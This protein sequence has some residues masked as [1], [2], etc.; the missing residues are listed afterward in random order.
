MSLSTRRYFLPAALVLFVM[1][2]SADRLAAPTQVEAAFD[3]STPAFDALT[4]FDITD[5]PV[6]VPRPPRLLANTNSHSLPAATAGRNGY[7]LDVN[8]DGITPVDPEIDNYPSGFR[9]YATDPTDP[10][11]PVK[12]INAPSPSAGTYLIPPLDTTSVAT[13]NTGFGST[14]D[15]IYC[16]VVRAPAGYQQLH[17]EWHYDDGVSSDNV[18]ALPVIPIINVSLKKIGDGL[19]GGPAEVCTVGW[20][21][22]FI[23]GNVSN[24]FDPSPD[25]V[26]DLRAPDGPDPSDFVIVGGTNNG[27]PVV[28]YV[29][30]NGPEWCAGIGS[31]VSETGLGLS[32]NID[33]IYN[34]VDIGLRSRNVDDQ[35]VTINL[36]ADQSIDIVKSVELRHITMDGQISQSQV[37]DAKVI[38]APHYVCLIGSN[39]GVN[40][41]LAASGVHIQ[42]FGPPQFANV[43]GLAVFTK[44]ASDNPRLGAVEDDTLCF[45]YTSTAPGEQIIY[46]DYTDG[47]SGLPAQS[48]FDTNN[49]GNGVSDFPAGSLTTAWNVIDRTVLSTGSISSGVVTFKTLNVPLSFNLSDGTFLGGIG[50]TE[51][52]LGEHTAGGKQKTDQLLDGVL[53]VAKVVGNCGYFEVPDK[54]KVTTITGISVGGRL[55]LNNFNDDPF[56]GFHGDTDADPD[57][58]HITTLNAGGCGGNAK[59][60][61]KVNVYYPNDPNV[62]AEVEETVNL[63]YSF[64]PAQKVPRVAWAGQ[65]VT[66]SYAISAE[67]CSNTTIQMLRPKDQPG[68][69]IADNGVALNGP[70][71]ASVLLDPDTCSAS[72]L[73]ESEVPGFIDVEMFIA[74]NP[75]SKISVP[76][77]FMVF[78]DLSLSATPDQFVSTFG[79][80]TAN[81]RGYFQS[82]NPSGR[83]AET[84]ADGRVVPKDR[85][86]LPD[87]WELLKGESDLR[88]AWGSLTM[89]ASIVTFFMENEGTLN[90]YKAKVKSGAAGFFIP[91]SIDDFSFN[92]NPHT[93]V[94]ALLG[95]IIKP[96]MMSSITD[97]GGQASVDT[98]GDRNLSY[99]G[100]AANVIT[101]N[102]HC[103]PEE[104]AGTTRYFAVVEYP[105]AGNRGKWPAIAS[106]VGE[107]VWR[108][109]GF[110]EVTIVNTD[111]P[112]IKYVVAHLRD[113]DG[114][115]DAVNYNNTLGVPVTFEI[116]AGD[117]VIIEAADRPYVI[118]GGRRFA[119]ATTFDTTNLLGVPINTDIAKAPLLPDQPDECQAWIK[120]TNS[121]LTITNV[122]VTFPAPPSPVPGDIRLSSIQCTE[123]ESFTVTNYGTKEVNL[124]GFALKSSKASDI[125]NAEELD[126][127]GVLQ[128]GASKTFFGGPAAAEKGWL[129]ADKYI[130]SGPNDYISLVWEDYP[131]TT[132]NCAGDRID[133]SPLVTFPLDGEGEIK[134][135]IIIPFGNETEVPLVIG[136]NLVSTGDG[137]I[138]LD[139][140]FS[141]AKDKVEAVYVWDPVLEEWSHYIP[142]APAG[143]NTLDTIGGHMFMWVLVKQPFTLTLPK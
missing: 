141:D 77:I 125:G 43:S 135:D 25:P 97:G 3:P 104:V 45:T 137:E 124:G 101:Q 108:W 18:I 39:A 55:E 44:S 114:F 64:T 63:E 76:I 20:D 139:A 75:Y 81:V 96:R 46:V 143:V 102:P 122:T 120:V 5:F 8:L 40:D 62:P 23:T 83:P 133:N 24:S 107:T 73:Y 14:S 90:N 41:A 59:A 85:W 13:F 69:F 67:D 123:A 118:N 10:A 61:I 11:N 126:L 74:N 68:A 22:E 34:R 142:G 21:R 138:S 109:A 130:L 54:T 58:L 131:L 105:E 71:H 110:K 91:D 72:V 57:D 29:R 65:Y 19:V 7:C 115:C 32:L 87:D 88:D 92:V 112:Q 84:K 82:T 17:V 98:F 116:D 27:P 33:A 6:S 35:P 80:V 66:L 1:L 93:K 121:L 95:T 60:T 38:Y 50:V 51:W 26:D 36:P 140:A 78:E 136:W 119:T 106:N 127:I 4:P 70:D 100:C 94:S 53:I 103:K 86:I 42:P 99:E 79:D 47:V 31:S 113:R 30:Q 2:I 49:D 128:P 111:S 117:G 9:V 16:V 129:D 132:M 28:K 52:V 37:S 134:L 48:T 89:P 15:D 12:K 56:S